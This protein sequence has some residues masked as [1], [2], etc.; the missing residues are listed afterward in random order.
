METGGTPGV[1]I[2]EDRI[3]TA[4]GDR[5]AITVYRPQAAPGALPCVVMGAGATLTQRDGIPIYA[6]R[7]AAAGFSVVA[8]DYRHWGDSDGEPRRLIA[9]SSQLSD[10]R[11]ALAHA[12]R[13]DRVDRSRIAVWGMSLGGGHALLTAAADAQIAA[14]IALVPMADG[15]AFS[16]TAHR[17]RV[18][19]RAALGLIRSRTVTVPAAG[20]PG[21]AQLFNE[22]GSL[23]GFERVAVAN[24]WQNEVTFGR[25]APLSAYRPVRR[26]RKVRA[27][28]L[29]QLGEH[30]A[31]APPRPIEKTAAR[32]P[33]GELLRYPIDHFGCFS[34]EHV[35]R[36]AGDQIEFLRRHLGTGESSPARSS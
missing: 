24:G 27:P 12:R 29:L 21:S 4:S 20:P 25:S 16:L 35:D 5:C 10:W 11:D 7:F 18:L 3:E 15:L 33:R 14:V 36:V 34:P 8:F 17:T 32:M 31:I 1:S 19:S 9:L 13:L 22:P 28:A 2:V 30:D 6:E 23:A 26:A